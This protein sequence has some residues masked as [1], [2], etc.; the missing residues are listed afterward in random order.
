MPAKKK[1]ETAATPE[2]L[3]HS[4]S[5]FAAQTDEVVQA[6]AAEAVAPSSFGGVARQKTMTVRLDQVETDPL[7][8]RHDVDY[9]DKTLQHN[10]LTAGGLLK[11]PLV[12]PSG[13]KTADGR[14]KFYIVG[15]N[16]STYS[17]REVLKSQGLDPDTYQI[18]VLVRDYTGAQD[19][20]IQKILE[21]VMDNESQ[22]AMSPID[23][24]HAYQEL[25]KSGL[26]RTD[27][28]EKFGKSAA[29]VSQVMKFS[30]LPER[31]QD[32]MHFESN[33]DRLAAQ[34]DENFYSDNNI[35]FSRLEGGEYWIRGIGYKS[36]MSMCSL[37]RRRPAKTAKKA[38]HS[39][40]EQH[41]LDV[42][43][44]LL[45]GD[46]I[47]AAQ[48]MSATAFENFLIAKADAAGVLQDE[49]EVA[50]KPVGKTTSKRSKK[51]EE[52][53]ALEPGLENA[54]EPVSVDSG[55]AED[56]FD[57]VVQLSEVEVE[58]DGVPTIVAQDEKPAKTVTKDASRPAKAPEGI[59][60]S[61]SAN[62]Y[63]DMI[64]NGKVQ[65]TVDWAEI[66]ADKLKVGDYTAERFV[67]WMILN[68]MMREA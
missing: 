63:A 30:M 31:I 35:P 10:I 59:S 54:P 68:D 36:G 42:Q 5:Q 16:R 27:I 7:N 48:E 1:I 60:A 40:W 32:L 37:F 14:D 45:R 26:S 11:A 51:G 38:E 23:L 8:F 47:V 52:V 65:L 33:K 56:G 29:H 34:K 44:F 12:T 43:D 13:D 62:T 6:I 58:I 66:L 21:M 24:M 3:V 25:E 41:V 2:V 19:K 53:Q 15:G 55:A 64:A 28:A 57:D 4:D 9:F 17:L 18:E 39:A 46:I 67:K 49:E 50:T 22:Q 61:L 20:H